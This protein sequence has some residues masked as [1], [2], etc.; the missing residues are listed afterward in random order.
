MH[1]KVAAAIVAALALGVASCG[2][3]ET[4]TLDRVQLVRRVELACKDAQEKWN[5]RFRETRRS[6]RSLRDGQQFLVDRLG[7]LDASGAARDDFARFKDGVRARLEAIET[8]VDAPRADRGRVLRS[9]QRE[10]V[11]AGR[12][13]ETAA[14]RLGIDGC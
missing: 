14:R 11:A 6:D 4:T 9:V 1:R 13:I 2:G 12:A 8:V 7:E 5:E 3:T 10:A